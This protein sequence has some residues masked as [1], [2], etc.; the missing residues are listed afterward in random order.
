MAS[1]QRSSLKSRAE[2]YAESAW[3]GPL[4]DRNLPLVVVVLGVLCFAAGVMLLGVAVEAFSGLIDHF[5]LGDHA[6]DGLSTEV[7]L[8]VRALLFVVL[9]ALLA[10][11]GLAVSRNRRRLAAFLTRGLLVGVFFAAVCDIMIEGVTWRLVPLAL[12]QALAVVTQALLDPTLADERHL[13]RSLRNMELREEAIEGT[14]GR[15]PSGRGYLELNFF[16]LFWIFVAASVL[17]LLYE[18][19]FHELYYHGYQNRAGLLFGPFSPIYGVGAVLMTLALNRL[20]DANIVVVFLI[21][22]LIGGAFEYAASWFMELAFGAV[23]WD[24]TGMW[25]SIGGRTCGLFMAVWGVLGTLWV[26]VLLPLLLRAV[27][28]IPWNWRYAVTG[29][30]AAFMLVDVVMTLQALDCWYERLSGAPVNSNIQ[31]FYARYFDDAY[32]SDRF[33]SMVI[34]P[35]NAVRG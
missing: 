28:L 11:Q 35:E 7:V 5:R 23:A 15:D 29:V 10:A 20:H 13:Q 21:S 27:N 17:G 32:M 14:L 19:T 12:I 8:V 9:A 30:C 34:H 3:R 22:A 4:D 1:E 18:N 16:N 2:Y 26:K 31:Q 6:A 24:Y 25:L 33:Q